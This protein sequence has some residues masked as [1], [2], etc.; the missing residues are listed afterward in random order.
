MYLFNF[1]TIYSYT[2]LEYVYFFC[3]EMKMNVVDA[4]NACLSGGV[5]VGA[6]A[7]LMLE[8]YGALLIGSAAGIISTVG[9][10]KIQVRDTISYTSDN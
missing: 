2:K 5:A 10:Q 1:H 9:Y 4:Q 3:S 8:P 7:H 6:I